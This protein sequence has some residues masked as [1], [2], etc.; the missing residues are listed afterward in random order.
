ML[1][2]LVYNKE[3]KGVKLET[4]ERIG[5]LLKDSRNLLWIDIVNPSE[6]DI[7][8]MVEIFKFHQLAIEDAIFPQNQP[9]L[10][11]YDE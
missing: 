1:Q 6:D 5:R 7:D 2:V 9:K 10:D 3:K 8:V 11:E 4:A